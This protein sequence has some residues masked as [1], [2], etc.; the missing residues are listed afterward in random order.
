MSC[1][2]KIV[3]VHLIV[4]QIYSLS[5]GIPIN[6]ANSDYY[7]IPKLHVDPIE[8]VNRNAG[9]MQQL[10][11]ARVRLT[12]VESK[13]A[14][15]VERW[16]QFVEVPNG[17]LVD[18]PKGS[19]AAKVV[20]AYIYLNI[21]TRNPD[22]L[23]YIINMYGNYKSNAGNVEKRLLRTIESPIGRDSYT[24]QVD[25]DFHTNLMSVTIEVQRERDG[26]LENLSSGEI[27]KL[28]LL[29]SEKFNPKVVMFLIS[30]NL[31]VI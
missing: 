6:D 2:L 29:D 4:A 16:D 18:V 28:L 7:T 14:N 22:N 12:N 1:F 17:L 25:N 27:R 11:L 15:K 9:S 5:N 30:K 13:A 20:L 26:K 23:P 3:L 10:E 21:F 24:V 19:P 8:P 31:N